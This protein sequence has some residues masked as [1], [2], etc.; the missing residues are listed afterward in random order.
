MGGM[1]QGRSGVDTEK[2]RR[3]RIASEKKAMAAIKV[4]EAT[5]LAHERA[6]EADRIR[7]QASR[8]RD[9]AI[10]ADIEAEDEMAA[11]LRVRGVRGGASAGAGGAGRGDSDSDSDSDSHGRR[12]HAKKSS[13]IYTMVPNVPLEY[14]I[15][16]PD[17]RRVYEGLL[18]GSEMGT[19]KFYLRDGGGY[20][21]RV[22]WR[23]RYDDEDILIFK[24][25]VG[26]R[27]SERLLPGLPS[28]KALKDRVSRITQRRN[29]Y[30][31]ERHERKMALYSAHEAD[32]GSK[33][34]IIA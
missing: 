15:D 5:K 9:R 17:Y 31:I 13:D 20:E 30:V 29:D 26:F 25:C 32:K 28:T 8:A 4:A 2:T 10:E 19:A 3:R 12:R 27:N 33:A 22:F 7:L 18:F 11:E 23:P 21:E 34:C 6:T 24:R 1:K 16:N 14:Y